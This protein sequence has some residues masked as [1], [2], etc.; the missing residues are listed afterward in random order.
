MIDWKEVREFVFL[1]FIGIIGIAAALILMAT[2]IILGVAGINEFS[3][4]MN[5]YHGEQCGPG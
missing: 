4:F 1:F 5:V 2:L 3:C